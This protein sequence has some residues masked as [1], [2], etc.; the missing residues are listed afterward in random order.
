MATILFISLI[1]LIQNPAAYH[2]K[3]IRV[4]GYAAMRFEAKA[5][6]VSRDDLDHAIT[7]N[8]I[9]LDVELT[10]DLKKLNKQY[11][12]VEGVFDKDSLGHLKLYSGTIRKANRIELWSEGKSAD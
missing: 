4:I 8:A 5:L 10:D 3:H 11:V 12:L 9:W 6:Y 1:Q 7:K 2:D